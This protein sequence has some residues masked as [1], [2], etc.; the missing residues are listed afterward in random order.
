MPY[1]QRDPDTQKINGLYNLPQP[2]IAEEFLPDDDPEV[3]AFLHPQKVLILT[4]DFIARFTNA[5]YV[6]LEQKR[7]ADVTAGKVGNSKNWDV[8]IA[9]DYVTITNQKAQTLK[10]GLVT[11]GI[12]TQA[13]AD[14]IFT[15]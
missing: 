10:A 3:Q 8:V 6:K 15:A 9:D 2:G 14:E 11:D 13:R 1:V 4:T 7:A 12:L 5:E